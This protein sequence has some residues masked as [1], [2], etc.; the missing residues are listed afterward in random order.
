MRIA[1]CRRWISQGMPYG[2][3]SDPNVARIEVLPADAC[4]AAARAAGGGHR[5]LPDGS[6]ED[7]THRAQF[8]PNDPE[9]AE[10]LARGTGETLDLSG[11]VA[12]MARYQGQ[13]TVFRATVPLG[14]AVDNLPPERNFI[15]ELVF[16]KLQALG[17][18]PSALCDDA[19]FLRR[20]A[21]DI[22]GRMPTL[23]ETRHL[24]RRHQ[25][26]EAR[27]VD[28]TAVR[29]RRVRRLF[30]EQVER[31]PA[32]QAAERPHT[33]GTYAFHEWIRDNLY[34]NVPY[35]QFVGRSSRRPA[36]SAKTRPSPGTARSTRPANSWRTCAT[37]SS[38]CAFSAP[39]AI[40]I[41][42]SAGASTTITA[43]RRSSARRAQAGRPAGRTACLSPA[44]CR[45]SHASQDARSR[46]ADGTGSAS[47]AS[48]TTTTR[49]RPWS[50]G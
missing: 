23:E 34:R 13:V 14:A 18:P 9:M 50:T 36:T 41:P 27:G 40:I 43:S 21:I 25:P 28:R 47:L 10:S 38:A 22:A 48:R 19:T 46:A 35:D 1:C 45:D 2:S 32:Q 6:I 44:R 15:D 8:E 17:V 29:Q 37:C 31:R 26:Q 24:P 33:R 4:H 30:R 3:D 16:K 11:D 39:S 7:V 20:A 5:P 49:V 12:V 42:S